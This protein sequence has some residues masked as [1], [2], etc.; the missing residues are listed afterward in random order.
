MKRNFFSIGISHPKHE[1]NQGTLW[2]HALS[3]G[4]AYCFTVGPRFTKQASDTPKAFRHI[5]M[6]NYA[7]IDELVGGLP[8]DCPLV[9]VVDVR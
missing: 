7:T 4:A 8:Y 3:F 9:G 2:R 1:V 5:P 6:F